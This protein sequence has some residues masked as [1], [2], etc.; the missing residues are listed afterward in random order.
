MKIDCFKA[1]DIRGKLD[2]E[3]TPKI[4]YRIGR[5]Y[6]RW[7]SPTAAVVGGDVRNSS[8]TLKSALTDGLRDEGV[9]VIDI[10]LCGTEEIYF[11]TNYFGVD[12]GIMVTAS[13]NP[14]YYNGLKLVREHSKPVSSDTG[15]LDIRK[16]AEEG[17]FLTPEDDALGSYKKTCC[18][19]AY[20]AHLLT[21]I[22]DSELKPLK[23]VINSGNGGA[24]KVLA[25]LEPHLPFEFIKIHPEPDGAFPKLIPTPH[26]P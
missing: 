19:D 7:L 20:V 11:A 23:I 16:I 12:G 9:H 18:F 25:A 2:D 6:A 22:D 24:G 5:A 1:Y 14:I 4:V 17:I 13:H 3:L 26:L 10:G 15:L 21:Y 8:A